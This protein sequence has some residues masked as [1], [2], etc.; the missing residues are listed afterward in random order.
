MAVGRMFVTQNFRKESKDVVRD[1][2]IIQFADEY[3]FEMENCYWLTFK[4][5]DLRLA[6]IYR[7]WK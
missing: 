4:T 5:N 7:Q 1:M 6:D 3:V 2:I